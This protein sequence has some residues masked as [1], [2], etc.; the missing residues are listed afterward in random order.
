MPL[1]TTGAGAYQAAAGGG[2]A[3][4][5][6]RGTATDNINNAT[7]TYSIN[8]GTASADRLVVVGVGA[9]N[10]APTAVTVAGVTMTA[11]VVAGA[12]PAAGMYSALVTSGSGAQNVV[13]TG[14]GAF[15]ECGVSV[16]TCTGL[17]SNLVKHTGSINGS[18]GVFSINVTAADFLFATCE[19]ASA[20]ASY[21]SSTQAPT[22]AH[23]VDT[24]GPFISSADWISI[25]ST[26]AAFS[27]NPTT[28]NSAS[29]SAGATYA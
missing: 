21:A 25:A 24:F 19:G 10:A 4:A 23:V 28:A 6:F 16:W 5:T 12:G 2:G 22:A 7:R 14:M 27:V 15:T 18:N 3:T 11:D 20:S 26:N 13:V 17:S 29:P 8:I 9:A 1:L